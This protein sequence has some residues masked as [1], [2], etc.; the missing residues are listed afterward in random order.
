MDQKV[1]SYPLDSRMNVTVWSAGPASHALLIDG[2]DASRLE[3]SV[4][5][6]PCSRNPPVKGARLA[7]ATFAT[8]LGPRLNATSEVRRAHAT[9][10]S[11]HTPQSPESVE[12]VAQ[13]AQICTAYQVSTVPFGTG[14][15]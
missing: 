6:L 1:A 2:D 7:A 10:T 8:L 14:T 15:A 11:Y 12:E 3:V 5:T 4:L 13:I 9:Y